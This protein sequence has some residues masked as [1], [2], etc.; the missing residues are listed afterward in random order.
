MT[1]ALSSSV[2]GTKMTVSN[3]S[4][5][6]KLWEGSTAKAAPRIASRRKFNIDSFVFHKVLGKGS[7]GKVCSK[8]TELKLTALL[9]LCSIMGYFH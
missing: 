3:D 6:D 7:F 4:Q 2:K 8:L 1:L 5:Y 9:H